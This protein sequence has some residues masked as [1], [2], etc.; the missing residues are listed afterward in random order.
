MEG[1]PDDIKEREGK[2]F[3]R[4]LFGAGSRPSLRHQG[5]QAINYSRRNAPLTRRAFFP[6]PSTRLYLLHTPTPSL[7][8]QETSI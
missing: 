5:I 3:C 6:F 2:L 4:G 1:A 8:D 7:F